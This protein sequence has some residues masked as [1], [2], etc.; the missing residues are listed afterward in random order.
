MNNAAKK[1]VVFGALVLALI[2]IADTPALPQQ[3]MWAKETDPTAKYMIDM[4]RQW[5]ESG[6]T[7][8]TVTDKFL[9]DDFQGTAPSGKR[10]AKAEAL[11][12]DSTFSERECHLDEAKVR[13][14][15][16][17]V[18]VVY[19][20]ERALRKHDGTEA[21]SC[22]VWTDT[23]LKRNGKWQIVAAQDTTVPCK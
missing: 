5:A 14:F 23:W 11:Q 16:E 13:F 15:G 18:A 20:S 9:A 22:L 3:S 17:S 8:E 19:G 6:C 4:E 21:M 1:I 12:P 2:A 7:H 10:Y